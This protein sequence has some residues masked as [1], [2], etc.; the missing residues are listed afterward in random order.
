M[1]YYTIAHSPL[2]EADA[3]AERVIQAN[4]PKVLVWLIQGYEDSHNPHRWSRL[5]DVVEL[6]TRDSSVDYWLKTTLKEM[7]KEG[8]NKSEELLKALQR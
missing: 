6:K 1:A 4:D 7:A 8:D 2:D 3:L 5:R